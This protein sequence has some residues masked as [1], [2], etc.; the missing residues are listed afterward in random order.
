MLLQQMTQLGEAQLWVNHMMPCLMLAASHRTS[1]SS[2][3][4]K[5]IDGQ[6]H[7]AGFV[8][9]PAESASCIMLPHRAPITP[10]LACTLHHQKP[11]VSCKW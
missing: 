10:D 5:V 1:I 7:G 11:Y 6:V 2:I 4:L 9:Q 8:Q 3:A